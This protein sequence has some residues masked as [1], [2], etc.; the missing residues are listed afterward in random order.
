[1][2]YKL[3]TF[4]N[5]SNRENLMFSFEAEGNMGMTSYEKKHPSSGL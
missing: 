3:I 1:M 2:S 4:M 5:N